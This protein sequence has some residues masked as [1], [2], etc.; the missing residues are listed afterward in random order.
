[1]FLLNI[2]CPLCLPVQVSSALPAV[3]T[4]G[5]RTLTHIQLQLKKLQVGG[6]Q[7]SARRTCRPLTEE[8]HDP[9]FYFE[10]SVRTLWSLNV[11]K[12]LFGVF[13]HSASGRAAGG[14]W[15]RQPSPGVQTGRHRLLQ[16]PG[17]PPEPVPPEEVLKS[18]SGCVKVVSVLSIGPQT[19]CNIQ[20]FSEVL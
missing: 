2:K 8:S 9:S 11:L 19:E 3:D 20:T 5:T 1:M 13:W 10:G 15:Q 7:P 14:H 17:G 18:W 16:R 6:G 12:C 4:K